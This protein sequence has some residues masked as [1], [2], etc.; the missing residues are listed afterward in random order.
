MHYLAG[1]LNMSEDTIELVRQTE[2]GEEVW[3]EYE[4]ATELLRR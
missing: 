2:E 1:T 3:H 4:I